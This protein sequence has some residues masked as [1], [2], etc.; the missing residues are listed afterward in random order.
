MWSTD[1]T[2]TIS[3]LKLLVE[4][5]QYETISLRC[6]WFRNLVT[7]V[8][9]SCLNEKTSLCGSRLTLS[10]LKRKKTLNG[11]ML[12]QNIKLRKDCLD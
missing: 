11:D 2:N 8:L 9:Q 1:K 4:S 10:N 12:V 3:L 5:D 7:I 6:S